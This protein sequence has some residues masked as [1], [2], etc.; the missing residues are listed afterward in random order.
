MS[1]P[2]HADGTIG[3][4]VNFRYIQALVSGYPNQN[5]AAARAEIDGHDRGCDAGAPDRH[6][7]LPPSLQS[8]STTVCCGKTP[9]DGRACCAF[10]T[11]TSQRNGR[12]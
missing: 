6:H 3:E 4:P 12:R 5:T 2:L 7:Q 8:R 1:V 10:T 9:S 11:A